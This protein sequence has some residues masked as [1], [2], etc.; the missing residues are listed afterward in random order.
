MKAT[1][2]ACSNTALIKYWGKKNEEL[3][4][5][6]NTS[7][8]VTTDALTTTTTVK[9]SQDYSEDSLILNGIKEDGKALTRVSN[10]LSLLR[11]LAN[12]SWFA[13]VVSK[14]NFPTAAGLASSASGFAA[15]TK[16]GSAALSLEY[17]NKELSII[18]RKGSG[19]SARSFFGGFVEWLT[20]ETDKESYARQIADEHWLDFRD[21]AVILKA[22]ER[23]M[24]TRE[25]MKLSKK[26]SPFLSARLFCVKKCLKKIKTAILEQ[27]FDTMGE[28]AEMDCLSMHSVAL[29][30]DPPL[31]FWTPDTIA[32]MHE[33]WALREN[34]VPVY[35]TID[36]GANIHL[37]ALPEDVQLVITAITEIANIEG[38][39]TSKP[40]Q[41]PVLLSEHLF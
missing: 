1:A 13:R 25:A 3:I 27:D 40:G 17:S 5:P 28:I 35:F 33:I 18:S 22:P 19:S 39:I 21:I 34:G 14:N 2:K 31:L 8:S 15:L 6:L 38:T 12:N 7:V 32:I 11:K 23:K 24:S 4:L 41:E 20:G 10:H 37:L 36:T 26:T 9:F 29:T 16:A 30:S